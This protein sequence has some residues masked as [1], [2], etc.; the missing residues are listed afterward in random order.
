MITKGHHDLVKRMSK[1]PMKPL[2]NDLFLE[3]MA[4]LFTEEEAQI[5]SKMPRLPAT[6]EKIAKRANREVHEVRPL[7]DKMGEEGRILAAGETEKKYFLLGIIPGIFELYTTMGPDDERKRRYAELFEE[8]HNA[9]LS[10]D[11]VKPDVKMLRIIP[12][13]ESLT[14]KAGVMPS[15]YFRE[16]IDRHD[17]WAVADCGCKKQKE[18]IGKRCDKPMEVC[19]QFGV[20]ARGSADLG[21]SRLLDRKEAF[22]IVDRIEAAGLVH[23]TDNVELP[24]ISCNCCGCCCVALASLNRFNT[25]QMF[26]NSRYICK[27]DSKKCVACGDCAKACPVG[28][29][30]LYEKQLKLQSWRCIGCGVCASKCKKDALKMVLR[31]ESPPVPENYGQMLVDGASQLAGVQRYVHTIGPR[32]SQ[33]LGNWLQG[34]MT[35]RARK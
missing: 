23:L 30:H 35:G 32:Y 24:H 11:L 20:A 9:E 29:L 13:Q 25:P 7:L 34:R 10:S 12:I 18:L 17:T 21:M 31:P 14:S 28:A 3:L 22:E 26:L 4:T 8:Y 1:N 33:M 15:D 16:V 27:H 6:A 5:L 19:M 2:V